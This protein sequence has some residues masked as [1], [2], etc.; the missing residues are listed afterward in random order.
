[1]RLGARRGS[2]GLQ[3]ASALALAVLLSC[4][5]PTEPA[6]Q[7]VFRIDSD[8]EAGVELTKVTVE[9][10]HAD[11]SSAGASRFPDLLIAEDDA[12][13]GPDGKKTLPLSG[14]VTQGSERKAMLRVVGWGALRPGDP[15]RALV[16]QRASVSFQRGK[17][18]LVDIFLGEVCIDKDCDSALGL[19]CYP[20]ALAEVAGVAAGECGPI[21]A[22]SD[23]NTQ[24]GVNPDALPEPA[25]VPSD[26]GDMDAGESDAGVPID[27][28]DDADDCVGNACENGSTC[29]DGTDSYTCDCG[30]S[31]YTG[32]RCATFVDACV[33]NACQNGSTCVGTASGYTCDCGTSGFSGARCETSGDVDECASSN[34]CTSAAYPCVQTA[35]PGYTCQGQFAEWPMPDALPG[36]SAQPRYDVA[37]T[38]GVV[39]DLVTGLMWQQELPATY[40]GCSGQPPGQ[41]QVGGTCTWSEAK[42]YCAALVL[43]EL[44]DWRLPSKIELESIV[45]ETKFDP[46]IDT[47]AFPG[48]PAVFFW[49]ASPY[50][51][52]SSA[53]WGVTFYNGIS[54]DDNVSDTV[55]VR[56]VR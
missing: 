49:S 21:A 56:C 36:P 33:G 5:Q 37:S 44:S 1:M 38:P 7:V 11:G 51:G 50:V 14:S 32:L 22:I 8:L 39:V 2:R 20:A 26:A 18:Q 24:A 28:A 48:A 19:V 47:V 9:V 17:T 42:D 41:S 46:A 16:E 54:G 43:A 15:V 29:V 45:D 30:S 23:A 55:S 3:T 12:E 35:L 25:G 4:A 52:A 10:L 53:A 40:R 27:A 13:G 31:G 34:L 6:T